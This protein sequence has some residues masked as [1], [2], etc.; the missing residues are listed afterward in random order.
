M[1]DACSLRC[2]AGGNPLPFERG[3]VVCSS[4]LQAAFH[5]PCTSSASCRKRFQISNVG[6]ANYLFPSSV[7]SPNESNQQATAETIATAAVST[8]STFRPRDTGVAP[9]R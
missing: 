1:P 2:P 7:C 5:A 8:L 6:A 3:N 9:D 4:G